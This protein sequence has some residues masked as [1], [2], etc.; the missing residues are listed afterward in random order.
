[1]EHGIRLYNTLVLQSLYYK[2]QNSGA[3]ATAEAVK[4]ELVRRDVGYEPQVFQSAIAS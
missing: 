3:T 1:M 2:L 4:R